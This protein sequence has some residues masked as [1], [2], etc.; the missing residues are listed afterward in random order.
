M[1]MYRCLS[2]CVPNK[3]LQSKT[4]AS[5]WHFS[6]PNQT[7]LYTIHISFYQTAWKGLTSPNTV[8]RDAVRLILLPSA[9]EERH[10]LFSTAPVLSS[11]GDAG[12]P[13]DPTP[14]YT[15]S[16]S[17]GPF[18]SLIL[19]FLLPYRLV[20]HTFNN[21]IR[22]MRK[23]DSPNILRIFGICIDETGKEV[24]LGSGRLLVVWNI[25]S[26]FHCVTFFEEQPDRS[27]HTVVIVGFN[28]LCISTRRFRSFR[29]VKCHLW[30]WFTLLQSHLLLEPRESLFR[31]LGALSCS[32]IW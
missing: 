10:V 5:T 8:F 32:K 18:S 3:A 22:T 2:E 14:I 20:R 31:F 29:T 25:L 28:C 4:I 26:G 16:I 7:W 9:S 1:C 17:K 11:L 13:L 24:H 23:F 15:P 27:P 30:D 21:E 6:F 19:H 12:E